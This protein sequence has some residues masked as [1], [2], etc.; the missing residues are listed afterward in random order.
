VINKLEWIIVN[1]ISQEVVD[2]L[3]DEEKHDFEEIL[4]KLKTDPFEN[5]LSKPMNPPL[6]FLCQSYL[7][8]GGYRL[9]FKVSLNTHK[10][11]LKYAGA[12]TNAINL[13]PT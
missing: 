7:G 11:Y 3:P 4:K 2:L 8:G 13:K 10:I 9:C 12:R 6:H 5:K 1:E